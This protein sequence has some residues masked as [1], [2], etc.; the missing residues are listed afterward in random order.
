MSDS[1]DD[2]DVDV[3]T[4]L[5][6][7]TVEVQQWDDEDLSDDEPVVVVSRPRKIEPE[8]PNVIIVDHFDKVEYKSTDE[9]LT[10]AGDCSKKKFEEAVKEQEGYARF[11]AKFIS[12]LLRDYEAH[13]DPKD[14]E[15]VVLRLEKLLKAKK[16][17]K[18]EMDAWKK[19][20]NAIT[21]STKIN[22]KEEMDIMYGD[23]EWDEEDWDE[24]WKEEEEE[25]A[26]PVAVKA[27]PSAPSADAFPAMGDAFPAPGAGDAFPSMGAA[28]AKPKAMSWGKPKAGSWGKK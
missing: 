9:I 3:N 25:V 28:A 22:A 4:V 7:K 8:K 26:A 15:S 11:A 19:K 20:S 2:W 1:D 27:A 10:F 13:L 6:K 12:D 23:G 18:A 16:Q 14:L 24:D 17:E 5:V 21:K